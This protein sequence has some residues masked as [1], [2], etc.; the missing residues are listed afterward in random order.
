MLVWGRWGRGRHV[1]AVKGGTDI[2][3]RAVKRWADIGKGSK[4]SE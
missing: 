1:R 2:Y 3:V 4:M